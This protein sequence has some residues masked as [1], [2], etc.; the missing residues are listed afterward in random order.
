M[1]SASK[2]PVALPKARFCSSSVARCRASSARWSDPR[3]RA[4]ASAASQRSRHAST[5]LCWAWCSACSDRNCSSRRWTSLFRR[6][7]AFSAS[8]RSRAARSAFCSA[9]ARSVASRSARRVASSASFWASVEA[10]C[11]AVLVAWSWPRTPATWLRARC[12]CARRARSRWS[13]APP[14]RAAAVHDV[15]SVV[16]GAVIGVAAVASVS[17]EGAVVTA[18]GARRDFL[19][20]CAPGLRVARI[21]SVPFYARNRLPRRP[22]LGVRRD[23]H[24]EPVALGSTTVRMLRKHLGASVRALGP[25]GGIC[26]RVRNF[27]EKNA[28]QW[29]HLLDRFWLGCTRPILH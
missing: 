15:L 9:A 6:A 12:R 18:A 21:A 10:R 28:C 26:T 27:H 5:L 25:R 11:S 4:Q 19:W 29:A 1:R 20:R 17:V 23:G 2:A 22:G 13:S 3:A 14:A 24:N 7:A 16:G 8:R